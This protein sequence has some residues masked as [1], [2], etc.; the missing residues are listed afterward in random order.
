MAFITTALT[1]TYTNMSGELLQITPTGS[2]TGPST[3]ISV[4]HTGS[5]TIIVNGSIAAETSG[6]LVSGGPTASSNFNILIGQQGII[7]SNTYGIT[8]TRPDASIINHGEVYGR[9]SAIRTDGDNHS[10]D[11]INTG[12]LSDFLN[13]QATVD[14]VGINDAS[15]GLY[16]IVNSGMISAGSTS[17]TGAAIEALYENFEL[18]NSGDIFSQSDGIEVTANT[19]DT[20]EVTINN[21][22]TGVINAAVNAIDVNN[23]VE[24][25]FI[26]NQGEMTSNGQTIVLTMADLSG[27][28]STINIQ[29]SGRISSSG[30]DAIA[31]GDGNFRLMNSGVIETLGDGTLQHAL[32]V[33]GSENTVTDFFLNNSGTIR[34]SYSYSA[35]DAEDYGSIY[36]KNSSEIVGATTAIDLRA[37]TSSIFN[38]IVQN[39]GLIE[40]QTGDA[41]IV[42]TGNARIVNTDTGVIS[43]GTADAIEIKGGGTQFRLLNAGL[44]DGN[45]FS[46][47]IFAERTSFVQNSF[48]GIMRGDIF[49]GAGADTLQNFGVIFGDV[50]FNAESISDIINNSGSILGDVL[51]GAADDDRLISSGHIDG[52]VDMGG[53]ND[54]SQISGVVTGD[55]FGGAGND[56]LFL[57]GEVQGEIFMGDGNDFSNLIGGTVTRISGGDG[58]DTYVVDKTADVL[59]VTEEVGEGTDLVRSTIS[60]RLS[61]NVENLQLVGAG[62]LTGT[63]NDLDNVITGNS[64]NNQLEGLDGNDN[65]IGAGGNDILL[66]GNGDDTLQDSLGANNLFG[67]AGN[68][69]MT[70]GIGEDQQFGGEGDDLMFAGGGDDLLVGGDGFDRM[71][72]GTGADVFDFN[73]VDE[74]STMQADRIFDFENGIDLIDLSDIFGDGVGSFI[75]TSAFSGTGGA[76]VGYAV[77][78]TRVEVYVDADG[79]GMNDMTIFL[80]N[81]SSVDADD[82]VLG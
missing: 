51:F 75:G 64:E 55:Y 74:S 63:G 81:L 70:S 22:G 25:V 72:G 13:A 21:S 61:Q 76:E 82:F 6:I 43:S 46:T 36:L 58:N 20:N 15:L 24:A 39:S 73:A 12:I 14:L 52:D 67:G 10:L 18:T 2:I 19:D 42:D 47:S 41:V 57:T 8:I 3:G 17:S 71:N 1:S 29:N 50:L 32:D 30:D 54:L 45:I 44:V 23:G 26:T 59:V 7:S 56:R 9:G 5:G 11:I 60:Y 69:T 79:D 48:T 16:S 78:G 31:S 65:L 62:Q 34:A 40:S 66:G 68:D 77:V 80:L 53:G 4:G 37:D 28:E 49:I 27:S 35:I 38:I 33:S